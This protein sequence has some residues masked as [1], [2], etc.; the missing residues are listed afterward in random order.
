MSDIMKIN[1]TEI[2]RITVQKEAHRGH[3]NIT[4]VL[5]DSGGLKEALTPVNLPWVLKMNDKS[6]VIIYI[7]PNVCLCSEAVKQLRMRLQGSLNLCI[8][9]SPER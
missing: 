1:S 5:Y 7:F 6:F 2:T 8:S 9:E 4:S 3:I